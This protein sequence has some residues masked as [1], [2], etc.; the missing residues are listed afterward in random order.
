MPK[1][2]D[3]PRVR[4]GDDDDEMLDTSPEKMS[5]AVEKRLV[6]FFERIE[7]LREEK[8]S[9]AD[10]EKDV[11]AEA[12]ATGYDT[13]TMRHILKLRAMDSSARQEM[14]ALIDTYKAAVGLD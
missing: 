1:E 2:S 13:K 12:K 5:R 3:N 10:D 4:P 7:R 14:E 11:F 9:I 8:K 6:Q